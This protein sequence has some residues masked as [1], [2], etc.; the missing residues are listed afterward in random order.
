MSTRFHNCPLCS[1]T[2]GQT[3]GVI[4]TY[5]R[6]N[7]RVGDRC[8]MSAQPIAPISAADVRTGPREYRRPRKGI[9]S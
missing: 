2:V 4:P 9:A 7:D 3:G 8:P 1:R 6:H 5:A